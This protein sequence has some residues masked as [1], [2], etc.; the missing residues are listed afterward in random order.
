[1][2]SLRDSGI[3]LGQGVK[4]LNSFL[5]IGIVHHALHGFY[6]HIAVSPLDCRMPFTLLVEEIVP[7]KYYT[8]GRGKIVLCNNV[9]LSNILQRF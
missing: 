1:M 2:S 5:V 9:M 7:H 6:L 3:D 4:L 8:P